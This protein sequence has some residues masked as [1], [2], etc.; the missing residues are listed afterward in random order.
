[1]LKTRQNYIHMKKFGKMVLLSLVT[2]IALGANGCSD[3]ATDSVSVRSTP[4]IFT[5]N[6]FT[7]SGDRHNELFA[8]VVSSVASY[9]F[10]I[11]DRWGHVVFESTQPGEGWD[12]K[13]KG[14]TPISGVYVWKLTYESY[15]EKGKKT[16]HGHVVLIK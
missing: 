6:A 15:V 11:F 2:L 1:M 8:P 16:I 13:V 4:T 3:T 9:E 14:Q 5:P 10:I 7:P 12:G